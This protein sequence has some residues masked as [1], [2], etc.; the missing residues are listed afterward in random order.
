MNVL[1]LFDGISCG[2]IALQRAGIPVT[3]Y[4]ASEIDK[5]AIKVTQSHWPDTVQ[6]GDVTKV[7]ASQLPQ[8]E[9]VL[10]GTPCQSF[11]NSGDG[12]GFD[13]KSGLFFEFVRILGEVREK[14]PDVL[15]LLENVKMK[16]EWKDKISE[17]LGVE[18][19]EI[20]SALI[21][22][23][24]R[25]R[26][27]WTNIGKINQPEDRGI[28]LVQIEDESEFKDFNKFSNA[29]GYERV[30]LSGFFNYSSSGRNG[31][32][33]RR[34]ANAD[35]AHCLI[36]KPSSNPPS[37]RSFTGF[38]IDKNHYRALS[39]REYEFCQTLPD[40]YT[41]M[42]PKKNRYHA[43]GNGWTVDVIAHILS[44]IK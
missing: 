24:S 43:I 23:Q 33:Q 30:S 26:L 12:T 34:I 8:I 10:A 7:A 18:P 20:N 44:H 14:N 11:S 16:K 27:Y 15:F 2:R 40:N 37:T 38:R 41:N 4:F 36:A 29:D 25:R 39:P 42:I 9:L 22:A 21:S 17:I 28:S 1:S 3:K 31:G 19:V 32:V 5:H 35:K 13:G 6:L